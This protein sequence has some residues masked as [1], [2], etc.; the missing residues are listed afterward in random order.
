MKR[1]AATLTL[2]LAA[3]GQYWL[4]SQPGAAI[5]WLVALGLF[6]WQLR[7]ENPRALPRGDDGLPLAA[8]LGALLAILAVGVFFRV[9]RLD[10]IPSGLNHDVAW[11]GL[12]GLR[13]LRGEPYTP[14]TH[15]AWGRETTMLYLQALG[16]RLFG[17]ELPALIYPAVLAGIALL[18]V[19]YFWQREM[20]GARLALA[21]TFLLSVSGWHLVFSRIGWRAVLQPLVSTAAYWAFARASR[22][23]S[24]MAFAAA[25]L[26]AAASVYT[27]NAARPLPLL[28][29]LVAAV[30]LALAADRGRAI[31]LYRRGAVV[32]SL[33]FLAAVA[34]MAWYAVVHWNVWQ[35]RASATYFL[36]GHGVWDNLTA[37]AK[38]Y[39]LDANGDD[40]FVT[41]P[42]LEWPVAVLLVF[43]FVR[44][45]FAWR[46]SRAAFLLL[47]W[48]VA[49]A[50][51]FLSKPN[52]NRMIGT[53]PFAY[54]FAAL[55]GSFFVEALALPSS[56]RT[57]RE[58]SPW[59]RAASPAALAFVVGVAL[60]AAGATWLQ[61]FG[62]W[63]RELPG[64]YPDATIVG[65]Y[66]RDLLPRYDVWIGGGNFPLYTLDY[67][68]YQGGDPRTRAYTWLDDVSQANAI[69]PRAG[70]GAAVI[71]AAEGASA[72]AF[73]QLR[74]R[75][76]QAEVV[77]LRDWTRHDLVFANALLL[78]PSVLERPAA[79]ESP[80]IPAARLEAAARGSG[81]GQFLDPRA[82][83]VAAD[84][85]V[86][87]VD[88]GNNRVQRFA[89]DGRLAGLFGEHGAKPGSFDEPSDIAVDG[90][91]NLHVVDTWNDRVQK[92]APDGTPI[93]VYAPPGGFYGPRAIAIAGGKVFVAD[94]GDH[95]IQVFDAAGTPLGSIG[96]GEG[97][98]AGELR[99]PEGLAV[100]ADGRLWV[101]D[102]G[103]HRLQIFTPEGKSAGLFPVP[104]WS[105]DE[106]QEGY[107]AAD[108]DGVLL[109][110]PPAGKLWRVNGDGR[111][112]E[113]A[114]GLRFP[115]GV[116]IAA[117]GV[118]VVERDA[119]RVRRLPR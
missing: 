86:F 74:R 47:G 39:L 49:A 99:S 24:T 96:S 98:G 112:T 16:I 20:F 55:G 111:F 105:A 58:G 10:L 88:T 91:G 77:E 50:P 70:R 119:G 90:D 92:L 4:D 106:I 110:D 81:P 61:Y 82:V 40:F 46:D 12:Y 87:V 14:Y 108:G 34:P 109:T 36:D 2:L 64:F 83:S 102:A 54:A 75:Y 65:R 21:A 100:T 69:A 93:A 118:Y 63:R 52:A 7:Q 78:S 95:Q 76:P 113:V 85:G 29:P 115:A 51:A 42:V 67:L 56:S 84:G 5:L 30:A 94:T 53:L 101:V 48:L 57:E 33:C 35:Q 6:A 117:D 62:P 38:V 26:A 8:E 103:N 116:A 73:E 79:R 97:D 15:E 60:L 37:L 1:T 41:T 43:G 17:V 66:A 3:T 104:G 45:L 31:V 19:F 107:L 28:F 32:M 13:I 22:T 72:V 80:A 11:N 18:P 25:G 114:R 59:R 44:C 71:L 68:T 9:H 89:A 27:Y 23:R